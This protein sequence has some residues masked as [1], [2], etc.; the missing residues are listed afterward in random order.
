MSALRLEESEPIASPGGWT[1]TVEVNQ[2]GKT[3]G[4]TD[5]V[6][7]SEKY[8]YKRGAENETVY[9]RKA[10][11]AV[12]RVSRQRCLDKFDEIKT[13]AKKAK[14]RK[15]PKPA[16]AQAAAVRGH[17]SVADDAGAVQREQ[18][19]EASAAEMAPA[20]QSLAAQ[21]DWVLLRRFPHLRTASAVLDVV[22]MS[23]LDDPDEPWSARR[24]Q[25]RYN[26]LRRSVRAVAEL[27]GMADPITDMHE[28]QQLCMHE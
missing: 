7:R 6:L 24:V 23:G 25:E 21:R 28:L 18:P 26:F 15:Q 8:N 5:R 27:V 1:L 16:V 10:R 11:A 14:R 9:R 19:E 2:I 20:P 22:R 12:Q 17:V 4:G 13:E 3:P